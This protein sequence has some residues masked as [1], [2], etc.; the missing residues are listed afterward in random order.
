MIKVSSQQKLASLFIL[1][2][3]LFKKIEEAGFLTIF[4]DIKGLGNWCRRWCR[5][6]GKKNRSSF[7]FRR[8]IGARTLETRW[9]CRV[10][11]RL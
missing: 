8:K 2:Y 3:C 7:H 11:C 6:K 9:L 4:V 1:I 5:L 10:S